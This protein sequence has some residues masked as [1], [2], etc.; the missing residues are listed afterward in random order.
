V[1]SSDASTTNLAALLRILGGGPNGVTP[2]C[3][4]IREVG[5]AIANAAPM[6]KQNGHKAV[7]VI[8]TDGEA[9][10]GNMIDAMRP[11]KDLPVH[12]VVRVCTDDD[13]IVEYWNNI[14]E[15]LELAMDILDDF[16][17]E[18][19]EIHEHNPWLVY[20]QPLN[21]LREWGITLKEF[22]LLDESKLSSEQMRSIISY[23]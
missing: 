6:L 18:A 14:D 5:V 7:I 16:E 4:H 8:F 9:S 21:Y 3:Y 22:D 19:R 2:L 15:E 23:L 13:K 20:G 10:D 17:G 1:H 12:I 11:L